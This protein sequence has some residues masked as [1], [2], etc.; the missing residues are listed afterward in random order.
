MYEQ[1]ALFPNGAARWKVFQPARLDNTTSVFILEGL[2]ADES[3]ALGD[4][5]RV[6]LTAIAHASVTPADI[7]AVRLT[8]DIDNDPPRH[9][10]ITGWPVT[11]DVEKFEVKAL[12]QELA[13]RA[14][15]L[16]R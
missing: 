10:A 9:A 1:R 3:W 16:K 14:I 2:S 4:K 12:A 8:L 15:V 5:V 13:A 6:P 7:Q 11:D